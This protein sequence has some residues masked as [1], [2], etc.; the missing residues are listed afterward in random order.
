[1]SKISPLLVNSVLEFYKQDGAVETLDSVQHCFVSVF[2]KWLNNEEAEKLC[3]TFSILKQHINDPQYKERWDFYY[4]YEKKFISFYEN[5]FSY[6]VYRVNFS[7]SEPELYQISDIETYRNTYMSNI[8]EDSRN[9][10]LLFIDD[11]NLAINGGLDMT[12]EVFLESSKNFD[13]LNRLVSNAGLHV[14]K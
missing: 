7:N 6:D 11:L 13:V 10:S 5:L 1:M 14:L 12:H 2:N 8:R 9:F 4:K 3:W